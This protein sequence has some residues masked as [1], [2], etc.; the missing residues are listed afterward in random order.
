MK[1]E[2]TKSKKRII[3]YCVL[4]ICVLLL[5]AATV[6]TVYFVSGK[7][8]DNVLDNPNNPSQPG[9]PDDDT[10]KPGDNDDDKP[11]GGDNVDSD[12]YVAPVKDAKYSLEYAGFYKNET[13]GW[14]YR[15]NALDFA[16]EEN[17]EVYAMADGT[18]TAVSY[19][20][21]TGNYITVEHSDGVTSLYRFVEPVE[22][23]GVKQKVKKG[24][25][26]GKVAKAYGSEYKDGTHLHFEVAK[27][28]KNVDPTKYIKATLIEK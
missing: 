15:H 7:G 23:L 5:A 4:A 19:N 25:V 20:E 14:I 21:K 16:A 17:A 27:D 2:K 11:T 9:N 1:E 22:G 6:L 3:Y 18:V 26:I 10:N 12:P 24:E 13:V 8:G 28:G